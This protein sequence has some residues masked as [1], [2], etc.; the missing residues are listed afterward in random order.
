MKTPEADL[1][2]GLTPESVGTLN[3]RQEVLDGFLSVR[4]KH[5]QLQEKPSIVSERRQ[6]CRKK[7]LNRLVKLLLCQQ[8][9]K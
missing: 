8:N 6:V 1:G 2:G 7:H 9:V 5:E 3:L 4:Q